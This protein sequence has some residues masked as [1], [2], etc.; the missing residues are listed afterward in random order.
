MSKCG[1]NN[2]ACTWQHCHEILAAANAR[3]DNYQSAFVELVKILG[4]ANAAAIINVSATSRTRATFHS[5]DKSKYS[6]EQ[7]KEPDNEPRNSV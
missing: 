5:M 3:A 6:P 4:Y 1:N 2:P 7:K